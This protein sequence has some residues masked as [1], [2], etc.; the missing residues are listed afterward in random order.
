MYN[1][2]ITA[3]LVGCFFMCIMAYLTGVKHGKQLSH[4]VIPKIISNPIVSYTEYKANQI[5]VKR[6]Q[7]EE[8]DLQA[9]LS[10][11]G[12]KGVTDG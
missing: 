6:Q 5:E 1:V 9:L 10:Y 4:G 2:I 12:E 8:K 7:Q 11:T 3:L